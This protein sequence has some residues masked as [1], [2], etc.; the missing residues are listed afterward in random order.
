[1]VSERELRMQ[2]GFKEQILYHYCSLEALYS[3]IS[4]RSFWLTSLDS[5]NDKKELKYGDKILNDV[6]KKM[7][8]EETNIDMKK[9]LEDISAAPADSKYKK[10]RN[11]YH[12]YGASFVENKDSLTHWERY[13]NDGY[14]VCIAFNIWMI[15]HFFETWS[16]PNICTSWLWHK[17]IIYKES[18]QKEYL[19]NSILYKIDGFV[20]QIANTSNISNISS[21]VITKIPNLC[22]T[23]YYSLLSQVKPV[24]KHSGFSDE[25][26]YRLIFEEGQAE[27][28]SEYMNRIASQTDSVELFLNISRHIKEAVNE[29]NLKQDNKCYCMIGKSIRSYYSMNLSHIWGDA[30]IPEIIIGPRCYQ[31]KKELL[32]FLKANGLHKTKV[33]ISDIPIR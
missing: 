9:I 30:L 20:N 16:L 28:M 26:E 11:N 15:Q 25:N 13:G 2:L 7:I 31:N 24:F 33:M 17:E 23:I 19:K 8:C 32:S 18:L 10:H 29:L 12:Y 14:G 5:T 4:S 1:M 27:E 21:I 22:N 6:L 3:I